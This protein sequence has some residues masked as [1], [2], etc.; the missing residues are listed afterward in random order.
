MADVSAANQI[1]MI[2]AISVDVFYKCNSDDV[3]RMIKSRSW[4]AD[5]DT[6][7]DLEQ[8]FYY[9]C[10][11]YPT[12]LSSYDASRSQFSSYVYQMIS[13]ITTKY[14]MDGNRDR[15]T[16]G[17]Y[18]QSLTLQQPPRDYETVDRVERF[19]QFIQESQEPWRTSGLFIF[20]RKRRGLPVYKYFN[21]KSR[22]K[23]L[24]KR[25]MF[26]EDLFQSTHHEGRDHII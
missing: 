22:Y 4:G 26:L 6:V 25:F 19:L 14:G 13:N 17:S 16:D 21:E 18:A 12:A 9:R 24:L 7:D 20:D 8:D 11:R 1:K 10:L 15:L 3:R 5:K 2:D 23:T